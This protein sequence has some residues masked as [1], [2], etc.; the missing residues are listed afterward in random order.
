MAS[1]PNNNSPT[2]NP[3]FMASHPNNS[4]P[5][6]QTSRKATTL[7]FRKASG[8]NRQAS[9][10]NGTTQRTT[11]TGSSSLPSEFVLYYEFNLRA[12]LPTID[13]G[14]P[15]AKSISSQRQAQPKRLQNTWA[16]RHLAAHPG[17]P[18][19]GTRKTIL[20]MEVVWPKKEKVRRQSAEREVVYRK[21]QEDGA[22]EVIIQG[23]TWRLNHSLSVSR[24][25][26]IWVCGISRH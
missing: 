14:L 6:T 9:Q 10:A 17:N 11:T 25:L 23:I 16:S 8:A 7:T 26:W 18:R 12:D 21:C 1:H 24:L 15:K 20:A 2:S 4:S 22:E 3:Q 5:T 13:F 19:G